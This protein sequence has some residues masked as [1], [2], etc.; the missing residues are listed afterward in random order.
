[1]STAIEVI[2]IRKDFK[3]I[4][5][6]S[7]L[8]WRR[9]SIPALDGIS[10]KVEKEKLFGIIGPNGAGKTTLIKILATLIR[11]NSGTA[12]I[13]GF[14]IYR[15]EKSI[16]KRIGYIT[17]EERSFYWRLSGRQN[18]L[19]F[20]TLYNMSNKEAKERA[21]HL[22]DLLNLK[23]YLDRPFMNYS[24]GIK[25]RLSIARGL[26][27]DPEILLMDEPTRSL[28]PLSKL[29]LHQ[30][31]KETLIGEQKKTILLTTHDLSEAEYLCDGLAVI[32]EGRIITAG[33][34]DEIKKKLGTRKRILLKVKTERKDI[35]GKLS[36]IGGISRI[37]IL[38]HVNGIGTLE[39]ESINEEEI[40]SIFAQLVNMK[41]S[42]L[43]CTPKE[44]SLREIFEQVIIYDQ[45]K[46]EKGRRLHKEGLARSDKL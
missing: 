21:N 19:F 18:L 16:R 28:D 20:A 37:N 22:G 32:S 1:M 7:V 15:Q 41:I 13:D 9:Q 10:F 38:S 39:L 46:L 4:G 12:F 29:R 14:D 2:D 43:S 24:S 44:P 17:S 42:I 26:I 45:A 36:K 23:K 31:I 11:P 25:Q 35:F 5:Y 3:K 34:V 40:S 33:P 27:H 30:F 8:P 6:K